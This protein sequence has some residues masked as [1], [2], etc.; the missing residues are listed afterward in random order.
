VREK[1]GDV[2]LMVLEGLEHDDIVIA[3]GDEQSELTD[4]ILRLIK[5]QY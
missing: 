5:K 1:G 3:L 2:Q 4:A